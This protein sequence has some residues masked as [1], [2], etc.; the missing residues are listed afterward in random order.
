[1]NR[2]A[3]GAA[4][5]VVA[6]ALA[7]AAAWAWMERETYRGVEAL[8]AGWTSALV[9]GS[10][11][12]VDTDRGSYFVNVGTPRVFSVVVTP[13]CSSAIATAIVL[14]CAL[15]ALSARR[16]SVG[17]VLSAAAAAIGLF[18]VV[19]LL[20]LTF[21]T[22]ASDRWGLDDGYHFSHIWAGTAITTMGGVAAVVAFLFVLSG[23]G[24]GG[25]S[26][27]AGPA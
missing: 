13:E 8:A 19:N 16:L 12:V 14:G 7:A 23:R 21:I 26:A 25:R 15:V 5:F 3:S 22:F 10:H 11:D 1:M 6:T 18:A 20:R 17:R 27:G 2:L 4:R 9:T 24:Q